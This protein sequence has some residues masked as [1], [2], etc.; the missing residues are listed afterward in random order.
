MGAMRRL[1]TSVDF[2]TWSLTEDIRTEE[3]GVALLA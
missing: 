3:N 1:P 2:M